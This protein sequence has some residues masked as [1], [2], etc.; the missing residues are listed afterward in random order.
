VAEV[1]EAL[2]AK[3]ETI[4]EDAEGAGWFVKLKDVDAGKLEGLMDAEAYREYVK[5][6][7]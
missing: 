5:G 2:N 3:P 7:D 4:N 1:N 6:L